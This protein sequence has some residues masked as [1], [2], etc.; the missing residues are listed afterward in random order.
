MEKSQCGTN[1]LSLV[2]S[3]DY[4]ST[5]RVLEFR[6]SATRHLVEIPI[7]NDNIP[8]STEQFFA[9]LTLVQSDADVQLVPDQTTI[10]ITDNGTVTNSY[11]TYNSIV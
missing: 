7:V 8:E 6:S 2:G 5:T 3:E 10:E 9:R 1:S 4:T 11:V